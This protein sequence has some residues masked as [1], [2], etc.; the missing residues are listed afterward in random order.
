MARSAFS[1]SGGKI[2][3]RPRKTERHSDENEAIEIPIHHRLRSYIAEL[4]K[5]AL[6]LIADANGLPLDESR[7]T[8]EFRVALDAAGLGKLHFH[9]LRHTAGKA[10]AEAGCSAHEIMAVLGHKTLAMA[11]KYTTTVERGRLALTAITKLEGTRTEHETPKP[12]P[13]PKLD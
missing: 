4:P 5:E 7:F 10:L 12:I 11:Q 9:G 8:K 3:V 1:S 6:M 13:K 2:A